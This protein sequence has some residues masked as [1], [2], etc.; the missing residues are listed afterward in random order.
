LNERGAQHGSFAKLQR[1]V[2]RCRLCPEA[3]CCII[4]R[5]L[6]LATDDALT[7]LGSRAS[8]MRR[9]RRDLGLGF[10]AGPPALPASLGL[11]CRLL[12]P[13]PFLAMTPGCGAGR[14]WPPPHKRRLAYCGPTELRQS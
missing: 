4:K 2:N 13:R 14:Q 3:E 10:T 1:P 5:A 8:T 9:A 7:N 6:H 12:K 11:L